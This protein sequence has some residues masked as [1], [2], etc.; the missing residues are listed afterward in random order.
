LKCFM[1]LLKIICKPDSGFWMA[2]TFQVWLSASCRWRMFKVTRHQENNKSLKNLR[3]HPW[4][5]SLKNPWAC[6]HHWDVIE[7]ARS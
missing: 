1:R 4:K 2:F 5:P 3:T 7:F 6:R